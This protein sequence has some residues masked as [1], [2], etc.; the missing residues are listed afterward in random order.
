MHFIYIVLWEVY[1]ICDQQDWLVELGIDAGI[2]SGGA[3]KW[4]LI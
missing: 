2:K 1:N 4:V 3:L